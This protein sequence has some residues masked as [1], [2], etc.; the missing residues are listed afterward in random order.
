M[1]ED[2]DRGRDEFLTE[3]QDIVDSFSRNLLSIDSGFKK[4]SPDPSVVNEAFRSIHTLKG[5]AGLFSLGDLGLLTHK[6]ED[7]LDEVRLGRAQLTA[8]LLDV[9][10][11][12]VEVMHELLGTARHAEGEG[13]ST[14]AVTAIVATIDGMVLS[15]SSP[16]NGQFGLDPGIWSVLTEYEEHRLRAN[17]EAGL[18]LFRV[19][20]QFD[21]LTIDK[22]LD[23][24]KDKAR[25][26]GEVITYLPT[27]ASTSVELLELDIIVASGEPADVVIAQLGGEDAVVEELLVTRGTRLESRPAPALKERALSLSGVQSQSPD[28]TRSSG[29]EPTRVETRT[30][31]RAVRVDI[32]K[33]DKL[34]NTV[35]EL[36][37]LR[38]NLHVLAEHVRA[39]LDRYV[40][41]DLSR[42]HRAFERRLADIQ[43]GILEMRMVPLGQVF[44]RLA[45]GVRQISRESGKEV[46]L[47]V[48]GAET[49]I[50]KLIVE[51]LGEPLLHMLRNAIDHGIE[52]APERAANKKAS[53]GTIALNAYQKGNHV[54]IE[55]EDDG[56]GIDEAKL[57]ERAVQLGV[58]STHEAS[59]LSKDEVMALMFL[60]GL[61]TRRDVTELSGRGVGMD[62][63][64]TN[65]SR[66]GGVIDVHSELGV[67]TKVTLTL[68]VTLAIVRALLVK[69]GGQ[70]FA[71]PLSSV[72]EVLMQEG[73]LRVVDGREIMSLRGVTLPLC[74]LGNL[75]GLAEV[76]PHDRRYVVVAQVGER[77][78]GL[79]LD[80]ISGQQDIVIKALGHSLARVRGFSGATELGDQ[81][82]GLVL[83]VAALVEEV[84]TPQDNRFKAVAHG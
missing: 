58:L 59:D 49:E 40:G 18:R 41:R 17:L 73:A 22:E 33:L 68:P 15:T 43:E 23:H 26:I 36:A 32:R 34:M 4:G 53:V 5:L 64:K 35:G 10:F 70:V 65:I 9:L 57:A 7:L 72:S 78:L 45:R 28:S 25:Q 51:E 44:D 67:G 56:Q 55:V 21:L 8:E 52:S 29:I 24:L 16:T 13:I 2:G 81:K 19:R 30:G 31:R 71:V 27:G 46:R 80:E 14:A 60:P 47:I 54:V 83:D 42:L 82:V 11:A 20:V 3:A 79:L 1:A 48:T 84:M 39:E 62:V 76:I 6:L 38:S 12:A 75:L 69:A 61:S 63:V 66:L 37:I 74:R 77:R 50:D